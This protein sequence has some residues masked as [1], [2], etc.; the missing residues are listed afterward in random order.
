M[1]QI[2][3]SPVSQTPRSVLRVAD[4]S[5]IPFDEANAD[6]QKYLAWLAEGNEP[7]VIDLSG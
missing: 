5:C 6:Y 2:Y 1:Y 4:G 7:E 3:K